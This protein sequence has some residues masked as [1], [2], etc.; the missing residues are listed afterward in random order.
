[1]MYEHTWAWAPRVTPPYVRTTLGDACVAATIP[2]SLYPCRA[3]VIIVHPP[4][5]LYACEIH[6]NPCKGVYC[7]PSH[8][9]CSTDSFALYMI[10]LLIM[11]LTKFRWWTL[12]D[13]FQDPS[14]SKVVLR[15]I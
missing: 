5:T 15:M 1:M 11:Y 6:T 2:T 10:P 3:K 4:S 13:C 14:V 12:S 7:Q 9:L 8:W